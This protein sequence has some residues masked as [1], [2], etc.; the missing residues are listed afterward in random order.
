MTK[1]EFRTTRYDAFPD[2]IRRQKLSQAL[3]GATRESKVFGITVGELHQSCGAVSLAK[4]PGN[5][6]DGLRRSD[7]Q[8]RRGWNSRSS[9]WR[10]EQTTKWLLRVASNPSFNASSRRA[11]VREAATGERPVHR[12]I[13]AMMRCINRDRTLSAR[14]CVTSLSESNGS[15]CEP[16]E[17][18]SNIKRPKI[19]GSG[20]E[21]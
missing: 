7:K 16:R 4:S 14:G 19:R 21:I 11:P 10:T 17:G 1:E 15:S 9:R 13:H 12:C 20:V 18:C 6:S 8:S 3:P 2:A 5:L